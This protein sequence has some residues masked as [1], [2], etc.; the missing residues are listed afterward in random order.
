[1]ALNKKLAVRLAER[2]ENENFD[3]TRT[4]SAACAFMTVVLTQ[5][6]FTAVRIIVVLEAGN[7]FKENDNCCSLNKPEL[8]A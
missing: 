8:V 3:G 7:A 2:T 1:L 6:I 4:S 5:F